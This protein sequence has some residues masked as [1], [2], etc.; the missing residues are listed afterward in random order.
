MVNNLICL[1]CPRKCKSNSFCGKVYGK[2]RIAKVMRHFFEEPIICPKNM[3]S[4]AV[5]F[6]N[7]SLKCVYCQNYQLSHL[8]FGKD[9]NK[10]QVSE[11]FK[12][13]ENSNVANL[14]LVT[15]THYTTDLI[16]IL[17]KLNLSIPVIWNTS[18][19]ES[20]QNIIKLAGVVDIF[21]FDFKYFSSDLS[22][23]YSKVKDYFQ[24][25]LEALKTARKL[26]PQDIFE[27]NVLKKGIIVRHLVLP[28]CYL[29]SIKIFDLIKSE[30]GCN[31]IVSIMSQ[32]V[33][34]YKAVDFVELNSKLSKLQYKKVVTHIKNLGF[35]KGFIQDFDSA[36]CSYTPRF[37]ENS[38][39]EL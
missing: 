21:L 18:G 11:I 30:I 23:K 31:F 38:F 14:N 28:N 36:D 24:V 7:C 29:D 8:G 39:W 13:V 9:F 34:V 22:F 5:F 32:F 19:Y 4:G 1:D 6:S 35:D 26:I 20:Q 25:C 2:I 12:K 37:D 10:N 33:P 15:P 17:S 16:D 3:G 27:N